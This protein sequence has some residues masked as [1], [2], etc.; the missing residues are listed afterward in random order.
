[1]EIV[2]DNCAVGIDVHQANLVC[3]SMIEG[4]QSSG[5]RFNNDEQ[6]CSRLAA[7]IEELGAG[8]V[9]MESTGSY[10]RLLASLLNERAIGY[11]I[12]N[13]RQ[14]RDFAK[15]IG[16][17]HKTD[18][19]D[20]KVLARIGLTMRP[21][22]TT[23]RSK[24]HMELRDISR[25]IERLK[26]QRANTKKRLKT[27][28]RAQVAQ[29]SDRWL[30]SALSQEIKRL[31]RLWLKLLKSS[32]PLQARYQLALS[33]PGI[34]TE[35]A[36]VLVSELPEDLSPYATKQL[37]AYCGPAPRESSSGQRR[38]VSWVPRTGNA[39]LRKASHMPALLALSRRISKK[40][41]RG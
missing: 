41:M 25:Q 4:G 20:A 33:V 22:P 36:R 39:H 24:L 23:P 1:M 21:D 27:P 26:E 12:L 17:L 3:H 30:V 7:W 8:Y 14:V 32:D 13:G 10:H 37:V 16:I 35:T 6:G 9:L 11:T 38:P 2:Q 31:Q 5:R 18:K 15:G 28:L 34:G 19:V 29:E 40:C